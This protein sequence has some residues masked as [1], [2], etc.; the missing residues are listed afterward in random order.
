[1][2]VMS[3]MWPL[4]IQQILRGCSGLSEFVARVLEYGGFRI[5]TVLTE[6]VP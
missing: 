4:P 2:D 6:Q 1:M 3:I 5:F